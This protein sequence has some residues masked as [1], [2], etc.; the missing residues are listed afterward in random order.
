VENAQRERSRAGGVDG[1]ASCLQR[2]DPR[3]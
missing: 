2:G 3:G 1:V